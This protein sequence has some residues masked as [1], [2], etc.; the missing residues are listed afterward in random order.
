MK[1]A[2]I[3][4]SAALLLSGCAQRNIKQVLDNLSKDCKRDYAGSIGGTLSTPTITFQIHCEPEKAAATPA[5]P[6]TPAS[7]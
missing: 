1:R 4:V 5:A 3:F 6:A 2:L 7:G